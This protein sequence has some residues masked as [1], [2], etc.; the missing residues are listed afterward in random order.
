MP[1]VGL[2]KHNLVDV[3]LL[4]E[5]GHGLARGE[6]LLEQR[7]VLNGDSVGEFDSETDIEVTEL[8]VSV[9]GHTLAGNNLERV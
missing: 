1:L 2:G 3:N 9:R 8:M 5:L 6:G 4:V 7:N